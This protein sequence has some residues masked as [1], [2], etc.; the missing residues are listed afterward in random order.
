[1]HRRSSIFGMAAG[2]GGVA[3][4]PWG[5]SPPPSS[6]VDDTTAQKLIQQ[7]FEFFTT[8]EHL[9]AGLLTE[10]LAGHLGTLAACCPAPASLAAVGHSSASPVRPSRCSSHARGWS[11]GIEPHDLNDRLLPRARGMACLRCDGWRSRVGE[12]S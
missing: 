11:H 8:K 9:P 5:S 12:P 2:T 1:M 7:T 3:A 4:E 10:R 6:K